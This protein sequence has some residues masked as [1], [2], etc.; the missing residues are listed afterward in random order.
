MY[1]KTF[2]N[3]R[4]IIYSSKVGS[5]LWVAYIATYPP[6]PFLPL[7]P[8]TVGLPSFSKYI[9]KFPTI[10]ASENDCAMTF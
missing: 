6:T 1:P 5:N 4:Y 7:C 8:L 3:I 2:K 9:C 10:F